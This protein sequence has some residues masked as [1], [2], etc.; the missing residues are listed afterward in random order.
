VAALDGGEF[1]GG[2]VRPY[3]SDSNGQIVIF[4]ARWEDVW[5][6]L[7]AQSSL[8]HE[9]VAL[10]WADPPYGVD[11]ETE[12]LS[13]GRSNATA[14][15]DWARV[16]GDAAPFDPR[17]L[18]Q[19]PRAAL[20]GANHYA[21]HLPASPS[22]WW[23]DKRDGG[24]PDD[25]AD[26]ELAWTNLGGPA[27]QFS[28]LWRGM[29]K[30]SEREDRRVH[31]TQKPVA[32]ATWGFQRATL[33]PGNLVFSPYMGSGPEARAALDMGLRFIGCEIVEEYCKAAVN[34]LRQLPLLAEGV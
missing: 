33:K 34:R 29:I 5:A 23:W 20:W 30:A 32:L 12:R 22:W 4:N 14:S 27:R 7:A 10:L 16:A 19:F 25:N 6:H 18:L 28:H 1:F 2:F 31:P 9:D 21:Q 24:T 26:G 3:Y 13:K 11:E 17:P 15:L 8:K